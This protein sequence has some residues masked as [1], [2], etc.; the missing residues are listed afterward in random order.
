MRTCR[1]AVG[2]FVLCALLL[3]GCG[4][5]SFSPPQTEPTP[6]SAAPA[7]SAAPVSFALETETVE[8]EYQ[9]P[10][11][12]KLAES[13]VS[14]P[15]LQAV[16]GDGEALAEAVTPAHEQALAITQTFNDSFDGWREE[17]ADIKEMALEHYRQSPEMFARYGM[18]YED[19][20]TYT[21]YT[22]H[23]L[24]SVL[25]LGYSYYGGAHP[26]TG[27]VAYNFD[28]EHGSFLTP[29]SIAENAA[30]FEAAV[31]EELVH[32]ARAAAEEKE[33]PLEGLYWED[34]P[35]ILA[36]WTSY[37]VSF[38]KAGMTVTFA[39]YELGCYAAGTHAFTVSYAFLQPYLSEYG[40]RLL[41]LD[42]PAQ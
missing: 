30:E 7:V 38:D 32:Q 2:V 34:Y 24:V 3:T 35:D 36:D 31:A 40:C 12:V 20:L 19:D 13:S 18:C 41:E 5:A 11:G 10:D 23:R 42:V 14:L 29:A 8:W 6:A 37:T 16:T 33:Q 9:S 28:L 22:T 21:A 1:S 26:N 25:F 27:I 15:V 4:A 39:P 17:N